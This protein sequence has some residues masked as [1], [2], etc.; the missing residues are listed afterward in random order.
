[1]KLRTLFIALSTAIIIAFILFRPEI[2]PGISEND[3]TLPDTAKITYIQ[4]EGDQKIELRRMGDQWMVN[5]EMA[6]NPVA[7]HNFFYALSNIEIT[8]MQSDISDMVASG[9]KIL[10][11]AGKNTIRLR[12]YHK[13]K[14]EFLHHEGAKKIY[15][16]GIKA[17][18][19]ARL[20]DVF[21]TRAIYWQSRLLLSISPDEIKEIHVFPGD[22]WQSEFILSRKNKEILITG[23]GGKAYEKELFLDEKAL[24]YFSYFNELFYEDIL[25]DSINEYLNT[26]KEFF[27][28]EIL[29]F[30]GDR[31]ELSIYP[32]LTGQGK[33]D[34]FHAAVKKSGHEMIFKVNYS[35][36]DLLFEDFESFRK[37]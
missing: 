21:S 35:M 24:M 37:N 5:N 22:P 20:N 1:M 3:F 16:V 27:R 2:L 19:D 31:D 26:E 13:G 36:L 28:I 10:I 11:E 29:N 17:N 4:I 32:L 23:P 14:V 7:I 30:N 25:P 18:S 6:V 9:K 8:G 33:A 15:R 12:F 34:I